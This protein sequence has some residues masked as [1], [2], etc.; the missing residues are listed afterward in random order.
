[1]YLVYW[2]V[3]T[4]SI[5]DAFWGRVDKS[6]ECWP[7]TG[8]TTE[9]GYGRF[10]LGHRTWRAHR[11]AYELTH[12]P[13]PPDLFV[14][15]RC[16]NPPCV[17]P[18]HLF[19]GD[20][21]ANMADAVA[22]GRRRRTHCKRG[23][24]LS[25]DNEHVRPDGSRECRTCRLAARKAYYLKTHTPKERPEHGTYNRAAL[26]YSDGEKPCPACRAAAAQY[27]R[28]RRAAKNRPDQQKDAA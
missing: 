18:D 23:H 1:M 8:P 28:A 3:N 26:H 19:L 9:K 17:R 20:H 5:A 11:L 2:A 14:L 27:Q 21:A 22:K 25:G 16:D 4:T 12:G 7:W 13:F 24:A 15:H 6:A 10:S